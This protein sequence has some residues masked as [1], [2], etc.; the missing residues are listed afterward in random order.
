MSKRTPAP[1]RACRVCG[2]TDDRACPG[3]CAWLPTPNDDVCTSCEAAVSHVI[4]TEREHKGNTMDVATCSCGNFSDR[5]MTHTFG[6][7]AQERAIHRHLQ[8][9]VVEAQ[10]AT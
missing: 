10:E 3:G 5:Q 7:Q 1:P 4:T 2:C 8:A 6:K 9:V